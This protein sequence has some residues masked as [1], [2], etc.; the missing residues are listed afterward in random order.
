MGAC[1]E[2][3]GVA[4]YLASNVELKSAVGNLVPISAVMVVEKFASSPRALASSFRVSKVEGAELTR[5][6]IWVSQ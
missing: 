4:A 5:L 6:V 3:I 1:A 2:V